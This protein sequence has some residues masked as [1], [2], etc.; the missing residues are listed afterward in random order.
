MRLYFSLRPTSGKGSHTGALDK[1]Q[2][3]QNHQ[4]KAAQATVQVPH[5]RANLLH[6][7]EPQPLFFFHSL[8]LF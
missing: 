8:F 3:R 1:R 4:S 5:S 6:P 7:V 2:K